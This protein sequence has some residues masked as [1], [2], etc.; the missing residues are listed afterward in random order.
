MTHYVYPIL[1]F[2]F[3]QGCTF[4]QN[5]EDENSKETKVDTIAYFPSGIFIN[6]NIKDK[7]DWENFLKKD[8]IK[9]DEEPLFNIN[10]AENKEIY[11]FTYLPSF[12]F[13]FSIKIE[14][15]IS[16]SFFK[17]VFKQFE[18][19]GYNNDKNELKADK[20][21]LLVEK[22]VPIVITNGVYDTTKVYLWDSL[23]TKL[24]TANYWQIPSIIYSF[25]QFDDGSIFL[26]EGNNKG[27]YH[28]ILRWSPKHF[29]FEKSEEFREL[30]YFMLHLSEVEHKTFKTID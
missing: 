16:D 30:C 9:M 8:L 25:T 1:M 7:I 19:S 20:Y 21:N 29:K 11:R 15:N 27:K 3:L 14:K 18:P 22:I 5:A 24:E 13:P 26:L 6:E 10:G 12:A 2:F 23:K 28:A 17:V 4:K